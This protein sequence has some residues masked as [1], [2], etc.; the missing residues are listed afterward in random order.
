VL[1]KSIDDLQFRRI[2][3]GENSV[4]LHFRRAKYGGLEVDASVTGN[5][6]VEVDEEYKTKVA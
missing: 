3:V 6:Q 4:D 1:P 2:K 5:L